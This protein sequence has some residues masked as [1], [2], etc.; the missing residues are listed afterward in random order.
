VQTNQELII[1]LT[2]LQTRYDNLSTS[3]NLLNSTYYALLQETENLRT[4]GRRLWLTIALLV[5][6]VAIT[7]AVAICAVYLIKK[8]QE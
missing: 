3:Y 1:N 5:T 6:L 7:V 8:K 4:L 2:L